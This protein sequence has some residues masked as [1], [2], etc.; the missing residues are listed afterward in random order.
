[1]LACV[2]QYLCAYLTLTFSVLRAVSV[3][4]LV[5][6]CVSH[7]C[8]CQVMALACVWQLLRNADPTRLTHLQDD[9]DDCTTDRPKFLNKNGFYLH[10][11]Q[12]LPQEQFSVMV[13]SFHGLGSYIDEP[14]TVALR[15]SVRTS[16]HCRVM[17]FRL[18]YAH[19]VTGL[20]WDGVQLPLDTPCDSPPDLRMYL[21]SFLRSWCEKTTL[22]LAWIIKG[23]GVAKALGANWKTTTH[24]MRT[25]INS[26]HWY[27]RGVGMVGSTSVHVH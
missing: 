11:V 5:F 14:G 15:N 8:P 6:M 18:A 4:M 26:Y 25:C 2:C 24:I 1:M 21:G 7:G 12:G 27:V 9:F 17:F 23:T 16:D 3:C 22:F 20:F 19:V 13:F 10:S